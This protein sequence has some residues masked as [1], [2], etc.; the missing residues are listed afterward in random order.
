MNF[1]VSFSL[2]PENTFFN[3]FSQL[4]LFFRDSLQYNIRE[5]VL[6]ISDNIYIII[7]KI[8][9]MRPSY[10][11]CSVSGAYIYAQ[12]QLLGFFLSDAIFLRVLKY[13]M[14]VWIW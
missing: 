11:D 4:E 5:M 12:A 1:N 2:I 9:K 6:N 8:A 3:L 10:W 13:L 7:Y 14:Y